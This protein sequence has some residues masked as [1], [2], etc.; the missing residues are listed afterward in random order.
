MDVITSEFFTV[1]TFIKNGR[2]AIYIVITLM[3]VSFTVLLTLIQVKN[4][5]NND[6]DRRY[7]E[8]GAFISSMFYF[9]LLVLL[10]VCLGVLIHYIGKVN[11]EANLINS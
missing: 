2:I 4:K 1:E 6:N 9:I 10:L 8:L 7:V 11:H 3:T 5:D